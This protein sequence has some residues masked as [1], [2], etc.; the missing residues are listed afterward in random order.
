[1]S[2]AE[3]LGK[4]YFEISAKTGQNVEELFTKII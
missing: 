2:R 3:A 1:M 4:P